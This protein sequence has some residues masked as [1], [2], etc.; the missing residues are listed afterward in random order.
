VEKKEEIG[1]IYYTEPWVTIYQGDA[2]SVLKTL[3][4][5][6]VDCVVTSPPYWGLRCYEGEQDLVWGSLIAW[7]EHQWSKP[8]PSAGYR[9]SDTNPGK[10]QSVATR[11]RDSHVSQFCSL[12]GAWQGPFGLEPTPELYIQHSLQFLQEIRRVLKKTGVVFYNIGDTYMGGGMGHSNQSA[13]EFMK[14]YPKQ[15]SV[16]AMTTPEERLILSSLRK[17]HPIIKEKDLCLIPQRLAIALQED[18][19]WVRSIICWVKDN[20]MP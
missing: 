8:V 4:A 1:R 7:C 16:K 14:A 13:E 9:S 15:G 19:W 12:C 3:P 5:E 18:G 6:S 2:L 17:K 11:N 20:P 10:L